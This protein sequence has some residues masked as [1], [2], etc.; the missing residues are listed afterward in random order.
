MSFFPKKPDIREPLTFFQ[1]DAFEKGIF[2]SQ[3]QAFVGGCSMTLLQVLQRLFMVLDGLLQLLNVFGP[4]F[5][6]GGLCLSIS[7]FAFF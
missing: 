3:H 1:E 5:S 4:P 2:I 6:E 7:L